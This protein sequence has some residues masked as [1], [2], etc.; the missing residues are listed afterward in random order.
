[1]MDHSTN[2]KGREVIILSNPVAGTQGRRQ[3][4]QEL[5]HA[6]RARGMESILC[7]EREQLLDLVTTRG[8]NLRCVVAAGGD[9][10]LN[11]VINRVP[12][13]PVAIL[14][15][16]NEN[17]VARWF[18]LGRSADRLADAIA[19]GCARRLDLA[20]IE[21]RCFCLMASLGI[22]AEVVH[23]VHRA[24]RGHISKFTYVGPALSTLMSYPFPAIE[25]VIEKTGERLEGSSVFLFNLPMYALGL[26]IARNAQAD[27]G[28]LDL[29]VFQRP[30]RLNLIR[31]TAAIL[32]RRHE[33]LSDVCYR[34]VT[35][36]RL[37]SAQKVQVQT[38]GD[39]C[40]Q[41]LPAT[42]EVVPNALTLVVPEDEQSWW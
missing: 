9:G 33:R 11:E 4:V 36:V 1:M 18:R 22:D 34:R 2:L 37:S 3:R 27:D 10:T 19:R 12:G 15:L 17:L 16:G 25:V 28:L 21:G 29:V 26:P 30:G 39:P 13:T 5:I 7:G 40:P 41:A 31:Y 20:R 38:D 24:R 6:L 42:I 8:D 23:A 35:R 32:C 14:P